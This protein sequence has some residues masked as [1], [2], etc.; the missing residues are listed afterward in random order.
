VDDVHPGT[1]VATNWSRVVKGGPPVHSRR[2]A[3]CGSVRRRS[4]GAG[5]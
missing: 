5:P 4:F 2:R 3:R 1:S